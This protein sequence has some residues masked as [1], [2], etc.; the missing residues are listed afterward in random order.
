MTANNLDGIILPFAKTP[1]DVQ[2]IDK[3][4]NIIIDIIFQYPHKLCSNNTKNKCVHL[5]TYFDVFTFVHIL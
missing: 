4:K 3:I 5:S 2:V 1:A